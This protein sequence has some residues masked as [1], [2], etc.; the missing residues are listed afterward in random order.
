MKKL[1]LYLLVLLLTFLPA[2]AAQPEP[3]PTPEPPPAL[4][5]VEGQNAPRLVLREAVAAEYTEEIID[6]ASLETFLTWAKEKYPDK[7]PL[8]VPF[9]YNPQKGYPHEIISLLC[10]AYGYAHTD[11]LTGIDLQTEAVENVVA[12]LEGLH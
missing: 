10:A 5:L 6:L 9:N 11:A 7:T 2:C 12:L 8:M 1:C 3:E 4:T